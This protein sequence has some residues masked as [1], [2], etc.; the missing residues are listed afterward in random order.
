MYIYMHI[1]MYVRSR[2]RAHISAS[3]E[4]LPDF[5]IR[6]PQASWTKPRRT[7]PRSAAPTRATETRAQSSRWYR[8]N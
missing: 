5:L 3:S 6:G 7:S 4:L 1:H 8:R 2:W